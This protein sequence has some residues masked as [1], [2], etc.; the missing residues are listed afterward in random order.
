MALA[1]QLTPHNSSH[2]D[3][4]KVSAVWKP[5][6]FL[7]AAVAELGMPAKYMPFDNDMVR[8]ETRGT[9]STLVEP[10]V[11]N[12]ASWRPAV[13]PEMRIGVR[14]VSLPFGTVI[15]MR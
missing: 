8:R 7:S 5:D 6:H 9:G 10:H 1:Q 3:P 14:R 13:R 12:P 11:V 15:F 4:V 2:L